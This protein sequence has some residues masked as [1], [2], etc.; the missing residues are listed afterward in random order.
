MTECTL[1]ALAFLFCYFVVAA[2]NALV[3][4]VIFLDI[5]FLKFSSKRNSV[6]VCSSQILGI[7]VPDQHSYQT[8]TSGFLSIVCVQIK[9]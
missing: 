8:Q 4:G 2:E 1:N 6:K 5:V 3:I 7:L 9:Q